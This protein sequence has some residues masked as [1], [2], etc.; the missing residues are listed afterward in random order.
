MHRG[1]TRGSAAIPLAN[2]AGGDPDTMGVCATLTIRIVPPFHS[3]PLDTTIPLKLY[4]LRGM[5]SRIHRR[6]R[7]VVEPSFGGGFDR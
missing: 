3:I 6:V 5:G 7:D 1:A 2:R 4:S